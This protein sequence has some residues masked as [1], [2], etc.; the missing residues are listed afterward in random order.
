MKLHS[1]VIATGLLIGLNA[2]A[3]TSPSP[4]ADA[5]VSAAHEGWPMKKMHDMMMKRHTR[6]M[7][8]LKASLQLK[9]EQE[10]A[11]TTFASSMK[12]QSMNMRPVP[13]AEFEKLTTPERIDKMQALLTQHHNA[14]QKRGEAAKTFYA[15]LSDEQK[16]TFDQ[17]TAKFMRRMGAD[18]MPGHGPEK[19]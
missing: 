15:S 17:Q 12:P 4:P 6:H 10:A 1:I 14:M 8:E 13:A 9:P 18:R 11:W 2:M 16:K 5:P 3:Q 19:N 7:E